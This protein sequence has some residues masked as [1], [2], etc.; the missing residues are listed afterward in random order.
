MKRRTI[1]ALGLTVILAAALAAATSGA[2]K[3]AT[4]NSITVWLQTDA[5]SGWADV[6]AA[7]N[8]KFQADHPGRP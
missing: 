1:V 3:K 7:A 5:Q 8:Q 4:A 2:T 6:V